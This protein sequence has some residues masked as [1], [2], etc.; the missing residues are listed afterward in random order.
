MVVWMCLGGTSWLVRKERE[1]ENE[2]E[3]ERERG[4][5]GYEQDALK[6][7]LPVTYFLQLNPASL[8]FREVQIRR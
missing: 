4:G 8:N 1:R 6:N 2:R 5:S 7:M 3:R